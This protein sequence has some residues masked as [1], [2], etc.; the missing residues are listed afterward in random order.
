MQY[1]EFDDLGGRTRDLLQVLPISFDLLIDRHMTKPQDPANGPQAP[2]FQIQI[3][4][5]TPLSQGRRIELVVNR[6]K[7]LAR[8]TL[9]ALSSFVDPTFDCVR[10]GTP[11]TIQHRHLQGLR[12]GGGFRKCILN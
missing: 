5:Q 3:Q 1:I 7:V 12:V 9:V 4:R 2:A 10:T 6:K 11:R 8:F